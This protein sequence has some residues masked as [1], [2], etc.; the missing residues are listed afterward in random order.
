MQDPDNLLLETMAQRIYCT[1]PPLISEAVYLLLDY[2]YRFN[3]CYC[4]FFLPMPC[5]KNI[6]P[7]FYSI[8]FHNAFCINFISVIT[9]CIIHNVTGKITLEAPPF[10][11]QLF[12]RFPVRFT[13]Q[14]RN[15]IY[16]YSVYFLRIF[17]HSRPNPCFYMHNQNIEFTN[18]QNNRHRQFAL[19]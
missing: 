18:H 6:F 15:T 12:Q 2:L 1:L 16:Q 9:K 3:I 13:C 4:Y 7:A 14:L 5:N 10:L 17:I 19:L 11:L 8:F